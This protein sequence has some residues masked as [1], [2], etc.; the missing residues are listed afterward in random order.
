MSRFRGI[1]AKLWMEVCIKD[2]EVNDGTFSPAFVHATSNVNWY[3]HEWFG[4]FY[5]RPD[6]EWIF[7][8]T[9]GLLY[10]DQQSSTDDGIWFWDDT[11][12]AWLWVKKESLTG[13]A[14]V[15]FSIMLV[16]KVDLAHSGQ[17]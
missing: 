5:S 9:H 11:F 17:P 1:I 8:T 3:E 16:G 4:V 10:V 15:T 6:D 14:K 7:H 12:E 13:P 2:S